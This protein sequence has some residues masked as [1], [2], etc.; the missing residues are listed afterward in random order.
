MIMN[1]S[2]YSAALMP[3]LLPQLMPAPHI[4]V[5]DALQ[6][7]AVDFCTR[8][9]V[10]RETIHESV[11]KGDLSVPLRRQKGRGIVRVLSVRMN[12]SV[13]TPGVHY[14]IEP[15]SSIL[16]AYPA[17]LDME[18]A[19]VA[20][21]KPS[22]TGT[23]TTLPAEILETGGDTL[24]FGTIAKVKSMTGPRVDW[25]DVAGAQLNIGLYEQ[26]IAQARIRQIRIDNLRGLS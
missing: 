15:D 8:T 19:I 14:F 22:R 7:V 16:L 18:A 13:Q 17:G 24:C 2:D 3:R 23:E 1:M 21:I 20:A 5:L 25:T 26:G 6:A 10:W 11:F 9:E 4:V 12:G